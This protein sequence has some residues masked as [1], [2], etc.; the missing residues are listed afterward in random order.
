MSLEELFLISNGISKVENL[1]KSTTLKY[2]EL[3]ANKIATI[4]GLEA[5][6]NLEQLFFGQNRISSMLGLGV[7]RHLRVVSIQSNRLTKIEGLAQLPE[8][9]E[10]LYLSHNRIE[11]LPLEEWSALPNL[12]ILDVSGNRITSIPNTFAHNLPS[13]QEFWASDNQL[14]NLTEQLD[15]FDREC[16]KRLTTVYLGGSNPMAGHPRYIAAVKEIFPAL[17]QIDGTILSWE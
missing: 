13:L 1:P 10:E 4:E 5:V 6:P 12:R 14:D 16:A 9:L 3:G 17:T 7:L 15:H 2:L 8:T 11:E